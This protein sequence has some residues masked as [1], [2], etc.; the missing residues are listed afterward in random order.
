V[1][2]A[3][4]LAYKSSPG[5]PDIT[6]WPV[7]FTSAHITTEER[8]RQIEFPDSEVIGRRRR[9]WTLKWQEIMGT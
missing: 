5:R 9:E 7:D 6:G 1:Q 4:S 3:F 2:R 8:M